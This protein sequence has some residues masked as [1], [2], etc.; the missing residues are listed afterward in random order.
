MKA[1]YA[2]LGGAVHRG[3]RHAPGAVRLPVEEATVAGRCEQGK[4]AREVLLAPYAPAREMTDKG[5]VIRVRPGSGSAQAASAVLRGRP[6]LAAWRWAQ[7][8]S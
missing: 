2:G 5:A 8:R 1:Q 6:A 3:H 4:G 7:S